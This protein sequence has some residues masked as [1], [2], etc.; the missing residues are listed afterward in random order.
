MKTTHAGMRLNESDWSVF[1]GHVGAT[2]D[3]FNLP[4]GARSDVVGFI[5]S[6]KDEIVEC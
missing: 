2:L 1:L 4:E 3:S 5:E 6:L